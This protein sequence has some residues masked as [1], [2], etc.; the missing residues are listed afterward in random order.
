M[1]GCASPLNTDLVAHYPFDGDANDQ[2][3]NGNNGVVNGATLTQDRFGNVNSAYEFD[4][5]DD[6][7]ALPSNLNVLDTDFSISAFLRPD[8]YGKQSSTSSFCARTIISHRFR[9]HKN[10]DS[11]N[12][13][14]IA[15]LTEGRGC[16]GNN[17][18]SGRFIDP[19]FQYNPITYQ[20]TAENPYD[21]FHY[22]LTRAL[23]V[24]TIYLNGNEVSRVTV[25]PQKIQINPEQTFTTVG[26]SIHGDNQF[27]FPFDGALDDIRIYDRA[28]SPSEIQQ[29]SQE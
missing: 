28:L 22:T 21:W 16:D 25:S 19:S 27:F 5:Q 1:T 10:G 9:A 24:M 7:I 4:G 2:S 23:D 26:A 11:M 14:L 15:R 13:G 12:S 8:D 18:F 17:F 20:Y 29:L 6:Y 3:G